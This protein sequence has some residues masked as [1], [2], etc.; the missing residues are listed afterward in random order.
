VVPVVTIYVVL[1]LRA[2]GNR[3]ALADSLVYAAAR[4][5]GA[6]LWTQARTSTGSTA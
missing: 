5:N 3:L 4:A 2:A 6:V 1:A